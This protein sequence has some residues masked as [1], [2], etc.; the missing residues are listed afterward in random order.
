M[1]FSNSV[2]R[3]SSRRSR[4]AR[5][6]AAADHALEALVFRQVRVAPE[7]PLAHERGG[8]AGALQPLRDRHVLE[9]QVIERRRRQ[10]RGLVGVEPRLVGKMVGDV[11]PRGGESR[12]ERG[13]RRRPGAR[14]ALAVVA[15]PLAG[16]ATLVDPVHDHGGEHGPHDGDSGEVVPSVHPSAAPALR[17]LRAEASV[18]P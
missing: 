15:E 5:V 11:K 10:V 1:I 6:L 13:A 8:V 17:G 9:R 4:R 2:R 3:G 18:L 16:R 7:V 14:L 12:D